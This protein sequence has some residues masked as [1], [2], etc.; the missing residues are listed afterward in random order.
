MI[1]PMTS[2]LATLLRAGLWGGLILTAGLP[3]GWSAN[4]RPPERMTYQGFLVDANGNAL[5]SPN[6]RN[7]DVVFRIWKSEGSTASGDLL[8]A[9][10]QTVTVDKGYFSVLL[11][12]GSDVSSEPRPPLSQVFVGPAASE[13]WMGLTVKGIGSGGG[14][15]DI[16]PRLRLLSA[17]YAFM[18][19]H[20]DQAENANHA[21]EAE[22][23]VN[24]N[25]AS[26]VT[27]ADTKVGI[28]QGNP[29][30]ALDVQGSAR[31]SGTITASRVNFA[32]D[33][34][35]YLQVNDGG[36]KPVINFAPGDWLEYRRAQNEYNFK[37]QSGTK[38][39]VNT[40]G[41]VV[42][43][44]NTISGYGTIPLGGI[45]MWS[46]SVIPDGWALCDGGR[47]N[48]IKTPDLRNRFIVGSG[49]AYAIGNKGGA[50]QVTLTVEQ[51]PSHNH[52]L[53]D[54]YHA[55]VSKS[56]DSYKQ[57]R[58]YKGTGSGNSDNDND[59]LYYHSHNTYSTGGGQA[60][61]NRPPYYALAFI[62][63]VK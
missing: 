7:Y 45:I 6:P 31:I 26:V 57:Y 38:L 29:T 58:G 14:D 10:Q 3:A 22:R 27:I 18:T 13:R 1:Q 40:D 43:P 28:N 59:Y 42:P 4:S 24:A 30:R 21:G 54:Y 48:N 50:N 16:L 60:H 2:R 5:G 62:M 44:P 35:A 41:I 34:S 11:G 9:E 17:P 37:L 53:R 61:E 33:G 47:H 51:I 52:S 55:E 25:K 12:E 46:G 23:L 39:Q 63:R 15:V 56:D 20:A 8:W 36:N 49:S 32:L 19:T